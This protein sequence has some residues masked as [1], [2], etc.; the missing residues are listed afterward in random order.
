MFAISMLSHPCYINAGKYVQVVRF[1]HTHS[2]CKVTLPLSSVLV[3]INACIAGIHIIV[4]SKPP[5]G[6]LTVQDARSGGTC[7]PAVAPCSEA[8]PPMRLQTCCPSPSAFRLQ[9]A[10]SSFAAIASARP[11][12]VGY[13]CGMQGMRMWGAMLPNQ[14]VQADTLSAAH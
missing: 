10:A 13:A 5:P 3:G 9:C 11:P 14:A 8:N 1:I 6:D 7:S 2:G 12:P 4:R